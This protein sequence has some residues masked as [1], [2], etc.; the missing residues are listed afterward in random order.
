M[1]RT[2]RTA[3]TLIELAFVLAIAG[4]LMLIVVQPLRGYLDR[5]ATRAAATEAA[6]LVTRA[7]EEALAQHTTVALRVDTVAESIELR[8]RGERIVLRALGELH[9]VTLSTTRDS[10]AFDA[11]GLGYGAANMTLTVRKHGA[12]ATVV[13]SRL[14]RVRY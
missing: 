3:F 6:L 13:V 9:G 14:G 4:L 12:S 7:R 5:L 11:R 2:H 8:A 10:I 1:P